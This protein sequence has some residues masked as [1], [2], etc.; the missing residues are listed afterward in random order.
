MPEPKDVKDAKPPEVKEQPAPRRDIAA[1]PFIAYEDGLGYDR[2][3]I[4]TVTGD[5]LRVYLAATEGVRI[6]VSS[7][8]IRPEYGE[9]TTDEFK[10]IFI[11]LALDAAPNADS[12]LVAMY[13]TVKAADRTEVPVVGFAGVSDARYVGRGVVRGPVGDR[14]PSIKFSPDGKMLVAC[15]GE[16]VMVWRVPRSELVEGDPRILAGIPAFAVAPGPNGLLA[17]ASPPEGGK[18]V[19]VTVADLSGAEAKI[20]AVYATDIDRVSA[21]AFKPDGT[22]LA[23]A[24]DLGGV[25]QLWDLEK[26]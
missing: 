8:V 2:N 18:K 14:P 12:S 9:N 24:D 10:G 5:S 4:G 25:V 11:P 17:I 20:L 13:G 7:Q 19:K 15:K 23:V 1:F 26:K 16:D 22:I 3:K 21:L 6:G